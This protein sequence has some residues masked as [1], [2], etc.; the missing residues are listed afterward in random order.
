MCR[1][2]WQEGRKGQPA[3]LDTVERREGKR[4]EKKRRKQKSNGV[5]ER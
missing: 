4:L 5:R 3:V 2:E 1:I